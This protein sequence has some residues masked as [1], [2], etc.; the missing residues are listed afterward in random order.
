MYHYIIIG[1]LSPTAARDY[2][3]HKDNEHWT[4]LRTD[5][6]TVIRDPNLSSIM[7]N[8]AEGALYPALAQANLFALAAPDNNGAIP[9]HLACHHSLLT[10]V[11]QYL[12][13]CNERSLDMKD[14]EENNIMH[15]ACRGAAYT[16]IKLLL[17]KFGSGK[18]LSQR[19]KGGRLPIDLLIYQENVDR[20]GIHYT[21]CLFNDCSVLSRPP[22]NIIV[23]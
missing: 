15:Y 23:K 8:L 4:E 13:E 2:K 20:S 11:V 12:I 17:D 9:L 14:S 19:N 22:N 16:T 3:L 5:G 1:V 7:R 10:G 21:E 6:L 18:F